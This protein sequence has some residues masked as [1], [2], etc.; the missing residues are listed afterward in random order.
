MVIQPK[1]RP[2]GFVSYSHADLPFA[3][4][5]G[6]SLAARGLSCWIDVEQLA[7]GTQWSLSIDAA[8]NDCDALLLI[9]SAESLTSSYC[10]REWLRAMAQ[11][12]RIV[13]AVVE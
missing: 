5:A 10:R 8:L 12:K 13:L 1:I 4:W 3:H 2:A 11:G 9:A 6:R 7:P